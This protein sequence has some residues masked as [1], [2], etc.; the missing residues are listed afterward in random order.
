MSRFLQTKGKYLIVWMMILIFLGTLIP[1]TWI[2]FAT[3]VGQ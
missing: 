3:N 1:M 2:A